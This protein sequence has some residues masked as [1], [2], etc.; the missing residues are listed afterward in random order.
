MMDNEGLE[1]LVRRQEP[2]EIRV[3]GQVGGKPT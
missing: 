3:E 2:N 1:R